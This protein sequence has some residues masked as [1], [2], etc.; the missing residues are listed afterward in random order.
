MH[1]A[2][3]KRNGSTTPKLIRGDDEARFLAKVIK[4]ESGCWDWTDKPDKYGYS[5]FT[6]N[7]HAQAHRWAY[8][9]FIG[10]IP[11]GAQ[12]D[13][14]CH[15]A[16]AECKGGRQCAHRRCVNPDHLEAV[17]PALNSQRSYPARKT[18]CPH[19]H[20][21]TPENTSYSSGTGR[22]CVTCNRERTRR[23]RAAIRR[24]AETAALPQGE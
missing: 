8:E 7:G 22:T 24:L 2:R 6:A 10:P 11:D 9:H 1:Y 21:Y 18:S 4:T 12:V 16:D 14:T 5:R 3:M 17:T 23:R 15:T 13:H 20:E 19:G